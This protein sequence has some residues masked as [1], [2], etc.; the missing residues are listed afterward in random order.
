MG[1]LVLVE[2][3]AGVRTLSLNRPQRH[4]AFNDEMYD[5]LR[6]A[7]FEAVAEP[8]VRVIVIRGEGPSFSSGRD[9]AALGSHEPYGEFAFVER[10]QEVNRRLRTCKKPVIAAAKGYVLGK[11]MELVL[12]ADMR[13]AANDCQFALPE[14]KYGLFTD[15]AGA[16][17]MA[18]I[19][20]SSRAKFLLMTGS[21]IDAQ[22]AQS[23]GLVDWVVAPLDLDQF[24]HQ[25]AITI[26]ENAPLPVALA[27]Q[28][29]NQVDDPSVS[30]G[31]QT[32]MLAQLALFASDD[33]VEAR[34]ALKE[35]RHPKFRGR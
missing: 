20:G 10:A 33:Y 21:R 6:V 17:L 29:V 23:W 8:M 34:A 25:L 16:T 15:N 9:T 30:I 32:E 4:N 28:I 24:T 3:H 35:K 5:E 13:V 27:K 14:V 1:D 2:D 26:A 7:T 11:A 18:R 31:F 22:Q 19:A 12:S